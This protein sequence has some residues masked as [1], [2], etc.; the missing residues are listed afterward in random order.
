MF[1]SNLQIGLMSIC[2]GRIDMETKAYS[3]YTGP[4]QKAETPSGNSKFTCK[5]KLIGEPGVDRL[6]RQ[7]KDQGSGAGSIVTLTPAGTATLEMV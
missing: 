3:I 6:E 5:A 4:L 7:L 1:Q 2:S